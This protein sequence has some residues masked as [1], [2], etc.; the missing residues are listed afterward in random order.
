MPERCPDLL[1]MVLRDFKSQQNDACPRL[2]TSRYI[3]TPQATRESTMSHLVTFC[4]ITLQCEA[5]LREAAGATESVAG[6][7]TTPSVC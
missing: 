7:H 6:V 3:H 1:S 2:G 5:F 4:K